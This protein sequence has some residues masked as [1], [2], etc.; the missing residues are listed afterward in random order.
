MYKRLV[1]LFLFSVLSSAWASD[2]GQPLSVEDWHLEDPSL[3]VQMWA[4][5]NTSCLGDPDGSVHRTPEPPCSLGSVPTPTEY[6]LLPMGNLTDPAGNIWT[7]RHIFEYTCVSAPYGR[8]QVLR[9]T[10]PGTCTVVAWL[11]ERGCGDGYNSDLAHIEAMWIDTVGGFLYVRYRTT[12]TGWIRGEFYP[13]EVE[14]ERLGGLPTLLEIMQS[15]VPSPK[16]IGFHV[17]AMPEGLAGAD[18]FD[19]YSGPLAKPIDFTQAQPLQCGYPAAP[20]SVGD[21]LTV[22]DTLPDPDTGHGYYYLTAVTYQGQTRYGRKASGGRLSGRDPSL[23][24]ACV[25]PEGKN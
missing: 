22:A 12:N 11:Q 5:R 14:I 25:Q 16:S 3:T 24:P 1:F 8:I 17:P 15:Y 7:W 2:F 4:T 6:G 18:H 21:Y 20:P 9:C 10:G 19:T 23:L 13:D